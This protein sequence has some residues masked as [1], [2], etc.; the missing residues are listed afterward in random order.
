M[1]VRREWGESGVE[2]KR[3][4]LLRNRHG[5]RQPR[6]RYGVANELYIVEGGRRR[7]TRD[8]WRW[9]VDLNWVLWATGPGQNLRGGNDAVEHISHLDRSQRGADLFGMTGTSRA[10]E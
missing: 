2:R 4:T 1:R 9:L 7:G 10:W 6:K 8:L 3:R 5:H